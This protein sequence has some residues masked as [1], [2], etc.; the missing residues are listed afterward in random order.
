MRE[1]VEN[2]RLERSVPPASAPRARRPAASIPA[3]S[4]D[5]ITLPFRIVCERPTS[6]PSPFPRGK[7]DGEREPEPSRRRP[8]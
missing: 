5:E 1:V 7:R 4:D 6:R 8:A 3:L 2:Q